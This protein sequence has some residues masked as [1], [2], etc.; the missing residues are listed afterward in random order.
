MQVLLII[1]LVSLKA[2]AICWMFTM[3][4]YL[5][6]VDIKGT[7]EAVCCCNSRQSCDRLDSSVESLCHV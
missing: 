7:L 3:Y 4:L 6:N 1:F 5:M 2:D